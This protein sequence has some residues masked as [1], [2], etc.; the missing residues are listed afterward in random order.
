MTRDDAPEEQYRGSTVIWRIQALC[1]NQAAGNCSS[2]G[3]F[4]NPLLGC[5][6][7]QPEL[8]F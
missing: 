5:Q 2:L 3:C 8:R 6:V 7:L 1:L 4:Y